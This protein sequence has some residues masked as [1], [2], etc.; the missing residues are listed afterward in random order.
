MSQDLYPCNGLR[1]IYSYSHSHCVNSGE[2]SGFRVE[3]IAKC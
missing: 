2:G 3:D 1:N